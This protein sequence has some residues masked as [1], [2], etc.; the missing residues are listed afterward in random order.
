MNLLAFAAS[1]RAD[2]FN[3]ALLACAAEVCAG[4]GAACEI[5]PYGEL[6]LPLYDNSEHT[7]DAPPQALHWLAH[8]LRTADG[9]MIATPEYNWSL[10]GSLKNLIDW[11]SLLPENPL[12]GKTAFLMS[13][14]PSMKGGVLAIQHLQAALQSLDVIA[15]PRNYRLG[16]AHDAFEGA[17]LKNKKQM[18][19]LRNMLQGFH[20]MTHALHP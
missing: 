11:I 17:T 19:L 15:Y 20:A 10:P 2:S 16:L 5:V 1:H 12:A 9:L 8:R 4:L 18:E 7:G 6:D 14:S 3:R 13:A